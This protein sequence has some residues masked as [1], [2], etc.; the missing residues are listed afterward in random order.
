MPKDTTKLKVIMKL[1]KQMTPEQRTF[2]AGVMT[3]MTSAAT[4]KATA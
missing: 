4:V 3:G 1:Y 2:L